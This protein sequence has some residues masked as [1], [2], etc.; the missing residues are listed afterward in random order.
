[1][2]IVTAVLKDV[3][4]PVLHAFKVIIDHLPKPIVALGGALIIGG[5]ALT[6]FGAGMQILMNKWPILIG[7]FKTGFELIVKT[8]PALLKTAGQFVMSAI[9]MVPWIISN[10]M[11]M[12]FSWPVGTLTA[13]GLGIGSVAAIYGIV[14]ALG[15]GGESTSAPSGDKGNV[16]DFVTAS[17]DW[18]A[19]DPT[20]N[21]DSTMTEQD[22]LAAKPK[23]SDYGYASGGIIPYTPGGRLIRVAESARNA[24][25]GVFTP[26]QVAALASSGGGNLTMHNDF[27]GA[28]FQI[29]DES[30]I[31]KLADQISRKTYEKYRAVNRNVGRG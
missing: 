15:G 11:A 7:F 21:K 3:V 24:W 6:T 14:K 5:A 27:S 4:L 9:K 17:S 23:Q 19:Q 26:S 28:I 31:T 20:K 12:L 25:E 16:D 2:P 22:W 1:M 8:G 13:I 30:Y 18:A 29:P 10:A